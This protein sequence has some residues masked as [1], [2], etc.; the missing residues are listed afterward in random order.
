MTIADHAEQH[1][2][3]ILEYTR[4][5]AFFG[6]PH[7]GSELASWATIVNNMAN[8]VKRTNTDIVKGLQSDSEA[9]ENVT[10]G[11]HTMLQS[12][13]RANG[14][15]IQITC[16]VEELPVTKAGKSFM[17]KKHLTFQILR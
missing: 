9:L 8:L 17:V 1:E 5:I 2:K 4:A 13:E 6:T 16:F 10:Q 7:Q 15:K 11:F 3:Q 14:A 12:R